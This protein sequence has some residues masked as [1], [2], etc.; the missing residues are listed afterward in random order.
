IDDAPGLIV[1]RTVAMLVN[2]AVELVVR[3]EATA[4]DVDI[5]MRLGTGYPE[6]LLAWGDRLG[7]GTIAE[8]L[9]ELARAYPS[10]RYRPAPH[11]VRAAET[12]RSLRGL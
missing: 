8:L 5:A 9:T 3:G 4:E 10:G 11:L 7:P 12:G 6:G 1:A 2:E